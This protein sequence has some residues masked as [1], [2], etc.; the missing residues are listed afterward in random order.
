MTVRIPNM[1]QCLCCHFPKCIPHG[2]L[3]IS[4]ANP[5]PRGGC[6]YC[7]FA[8]GHA[9]NEGASDF[10]LAAEAVTGRG[11]QQPETVPGIRAGNL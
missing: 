10:S 5:Y 8:S 6:I 9:E 4:S 3:H 2:I 7:S 11:L 1:R